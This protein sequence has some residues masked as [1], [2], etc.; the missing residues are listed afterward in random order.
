MSA[1]EEL[2]AEANEAKAKLAEGIRL[3]NE[4]ADILEGYCYPWYDETEMN[5]LTKRIMRSRR[6]D[7]EMNAVIMKD[8]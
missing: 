8:D 2:I 6:V 3:I 5:E 7:R 1:T 4:A